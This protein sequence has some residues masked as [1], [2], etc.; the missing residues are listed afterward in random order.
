MNRTFFFATALYLVFVIYGSLV[1]LD[2]KD[3]PLETAINQFK[4]IRFLNLGAESRADWIA[5]I[6]LYI[7]LAYGACSSFGHINSRLTRLLIAIFVFIFCVALAI[8][9]EF[10][11]L[12]FP[13]RTVSLNDLIAETLGTVIGIA[14]WLFLGD[15]FT[16][17]YRNIG[18]NNLFSAQAA[19]IFYLLVYISLSLFPFDFVVSFAELNTK[20]ANSNDALFISFDSCSREP[21]RCGVKLLVEMLVILPLGILFCYLPYLTHRLTI[22]LL[23]GFFLGLAIESAQVFLLSGS[24]QGLSVVTRMIGMGLGA[25]IFTQAKQLDFDELMHQLKKVIWFIVPPYVVLVLSING[26]ISAEWLSLEQALEELTET[27][28]LPLYYF[29]Y[30]S[31]GVALVSLLSNLGMYL[32]VGI[33]CWVKFFKSNQEENKLQSLHWFYAGLLAALFALLI[34]TG[35]LFLVNKHADPSDIWLAFAA[36]SGCYL[37]LSHL[38]NWLKT[39]KTSFYQTQAVD[40]HSNQIQVEAQTTE[41]SINSELPTEET[42]KRWRI[43]S[44]ILWTILVAALLDY[45]IA[46]P[47]LGLFLIAYTALLIFFPFAWLIV[48]PALLP[49]MDFAPWTGRFF[50]DEFDLVILATLAFYFWQKPKWNQRSL[51][52][53]PA[54]LL[55]IVFAVLYSV[56]LLRGLLP[57]PELNANAFNN[58]Y[59]QYNSLRVGK[60]FIWSLLLLPLLQLAVRRYRLAPQYFGYGMLL[61]L[62][63]VSVFAI[64]ERIVFVGLFDFSSDYRINALF[65]SMHAGGGHIESY[66]MLSLPFIT[67][68]FVNTRQNLVRILSGIALFTIGLYTLLVTFSRGGYIGFVFGFSVLLIALLICFKNQLRVSK[69]PILILGLSAIGVLVAWPVLQGDMIQHRFS[70]VD[71]DRESRTYHWQDALA[72]RN[73]DI[74]TLL[75]GMGLGSYP[76]TFFWLNT[77]N[78]HPATYEIANENSNN[79]LRLRG[80]DSLFLGQYLSIEPHTPY[81]LVFDLRSEN[82]N[83][84]LSS[85]LCEKSVQYS[86]RCSTV[87]TKSKHSDWE[88]FEQVINSN[89]VG[90]PVAA[91]L[92]KRPVKLTFYNGNGRGKL[93]DVD[94]IQLLNPSETNILANGD[95]NEGRDFWFFAAEKHNPWHIFNFWVHLIFDQGWLGVCAFILLFINAIYKCYQQLS[96]QNVFAAILLS[97]F[98]GFMVVGFVD[99]PFDAPRLTLLFFLM[100]FFALLRRPRTWA[101][102]E[103]AY[104]A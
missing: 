34:E 81:R 91:G 62:T 101:K 49:I 92:L 96:R 63:G 79:Y 70:V 89:D 80:G 48:I 16:N 98:T 97:S 77:E 46:A 102:M 29:Y 22:T 37:F 94:N 65:S 66:L 59:S 7:P 75:F 71:Q 51:L 21:V 90:E 50:F 39:R 19:I 45:P 6:L 23:F 36:A 41:N 72:I 27:R 60:G 10:T 83:M 3:L 95:F 103:T 84:S 18:R 88:H 78:T 28:F 67:L 86:F 74:P 31:E 40:S 25:V 9:V 55:L 33:L 42:D 76:R 11:Q 2:A 53:I 54:T 15:Y 44:V 14:S 69:K 100:L 17:L 12:F 5:N 64:F 38:V 20:L 32:P 43:V 1:P 58:Y 68:L 104:K 8:A 26:W 52:S 99:S 4:N 61:G 35:K 87:I 30:T 85:S 56:S 47:G 82:Q 24:G 93:L 13:P 73:D 57:L